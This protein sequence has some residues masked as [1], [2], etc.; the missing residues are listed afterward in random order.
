[1][2]HCTSTEGSTEKPQSAPC[3]RV[4][5]GSI[6]NSSIRQRLKTREELFDWYFPSH[7]CM[8]FS[9]SWA[10][11]YSMS[12][13]DSSE[14]YGLSRQLASTTMAL[15]GFCPRRNASMGSVGSFGFHDAQIWLP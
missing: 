9:G 8:Y 1:M 7:T 13:R 10:R 2:A 15:S 12:R 6:S 14:K 4:H 3:R 5:D 11:S